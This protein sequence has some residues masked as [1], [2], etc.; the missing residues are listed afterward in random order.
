ME[1]SPSSPS[2][3][4]CKIIIFCPWKY[5]VTVI[6]TS[7][8][9][10]FARLKTKGI[11]PIC[12]VLVTV[13]FDLQ[14]DIHQIWE[15]SQSQN[16]RLQWPLTSNNWIRSFITFSVVLYQIVEKPLGWG[17]NVFMN[18]KKST[19]LQLKHLRRLVV[20]VAQGTIPFFL[21]GQCNPLAP[22]LC[23][24]IAQAGVNCGRYFDKT[25]TTSCFLNAASYFFLNWKGQDW[26]AEVEFW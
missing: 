1:S 9:D 3:G 10:I 26:V 14:V 15:L 25:D 20:V 23:N 19:S 24:I 12:K 13:T 6:L 22:Y 11:T 8:A 7:K 21:V 18:S 5:E 16:V 17:Q 4:L 2:V